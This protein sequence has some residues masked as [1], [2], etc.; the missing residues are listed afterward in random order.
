MR[1]TEQ[2]EEALDKLP[3]L[4][5]ER[6]GMDVVIERYVVYLRAIG[7]TWS[8]IGEALGISRQAAHRRWSSPT[9]DALTPPGATS[10]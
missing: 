1:M 3:A 9:R 8:A 2:H 5:A 4:I 7:V 6:D 10:R